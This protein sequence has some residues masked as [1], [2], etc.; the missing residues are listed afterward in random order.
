MATGLPLARQRSDCDHVVVLRQHASGHDQVG[1][2][3]IGGREFLDVAVDQ[4][5]CPCFR[6]QRGH[7]NQ[8]ERSSR[9]FG[10]HQLAGRRKIPESAGTE[11]RVDHQNVARARHQSPYAPLGQLVLP[12]IDYAKTCFHRTRGWLIHLVPNCSAMQRTKKPKVQIKRQKGVARLGYRIYI[13]G[14]YMGTGSTR[15]SARDGAQRM[16]VIYAT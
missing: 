3:E 12:A 14:T 5:D 8:A 2:G 4:A 13:D 7:G 9:I 6:Q 10:P 1:P 16:L 11:A 15:A